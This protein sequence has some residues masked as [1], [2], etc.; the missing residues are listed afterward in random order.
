MDSKQDAFRIEGLNGEKKLSGTI[1][2]SGAKNNALPLLASSVLFQTPVTFSN[3]PAITDVDKMIALLEGAGARVTRNG[4]SITIDASAVVHGALDIAIANKFRASII[5][6]GALLAR[7]H[8][9]TFPSPGG[10]VIGERPIDLFLSGYKAAGAT[11]HESDALFTVE[12]D[13][14]KGS[15]FFFPIQS[16]TGTETL[17][18]ASVLA[19]GT[20]VLKNVALEPEVTDLA[21][22]L[23]KA[24]AQIEGIGTNTL[25]IVGTNGIPLSY[26]QAEAHLVI[27]DR[28]EAG[29][30]LVLGALCAEQLTIT[31]CNPADLELPLQMLQ[32]AGVLLSVHADSIT[33]TNNTESNSTLSPLRIR[34]HEYPGFPTDLQSPFLVLCTQAHGESVVEE[35]IFEGR[36]GYTAD[37]VSM[38]ADVVMVHPHKALVKGPAKLTGREL[39]TPDLRAGLAYIIAASVGKGTSLIHNIHWV[40]R[41]Y[42]DAVAKMQGIGLSIER[43]TL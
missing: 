6:T 42:E 24:G 3:V 38:G 20:T 12:A 27:P 19:H 7:T 10:C 33:I 22:F 23:K 16:V 25:T 32:Q 5:L 40:D 4:D 8:H 31:N 13:T 15:E 37:L 17:L 1:A 28:I 14:Y 9:V 18:M 29:S 2:I 39:Y 21:V 11:V 34:T 41:G 36:L 30:Y 26:Q 43:I 35:M